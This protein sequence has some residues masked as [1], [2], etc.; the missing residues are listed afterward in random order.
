MLAPATWGGVE[1]NGSGGCLVM[2]GVSSEGSGADGGTMDD[3]TE[4]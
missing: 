2:V 3:G 1:G 4:S